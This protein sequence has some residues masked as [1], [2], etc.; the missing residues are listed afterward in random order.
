MKDYQCL[1]G[2]I[3]DS[4]SKLITAYD[5]GYKKALEDDA[6]SVRN[7]RS[8]LEEKAYERGVK[9]MFDAISKMLCAV[10]DG[11]YT[12]KELDDIFGEC[13]TANILPRFSDNPLLLIENIKEYE[14]N[15]KKQESDI[16]CHYLNR[17]CPYDIPCFTCDVC[18]AFKAAMEKTKE[19][20]N[21]SYG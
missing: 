7:S 5:K 9:D 8:V 16:H 13:I 21:A 3:E 20:D 6:D 14:E 12:A 19:N 4:K 17:T 2:M 10:D 1:K 11:G 18:K 15:K